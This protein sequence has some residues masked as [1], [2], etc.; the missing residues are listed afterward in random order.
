[1][2]NPVDYRLIAELTPLD[3][4]KENNRGLPLGN[5]TSQ[6]FANIYLNELDL[7][8]KHGLKIKYYL[9]YADDFIILS[10]FL[11]CPSSSP[12]SQPSQSPFH[13][14][15]PVVCKSLFEYY[16]QVQKN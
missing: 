7:F 13:Y 6:L 10:S 4:E 16:L 14:Y 15:I 1:M 12:F 11:F 2:A 5:V 9:R 3:F 8:I